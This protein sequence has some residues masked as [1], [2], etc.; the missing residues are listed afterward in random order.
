MKVNKIALIKGSNE[1]KFMT[2]RGRKFAKELRELKPRENNIKTIEV[3][4]STRLGFYISDSKD[5]NYIGCLN[6]ENIWYSVEKVVI[7]LIEDLMGYAIVM[8]V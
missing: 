5:I 2:E 6:I 3:A 4:Y 8:E 7:A 1:W